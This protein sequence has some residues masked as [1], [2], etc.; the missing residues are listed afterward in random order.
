MNAAF[1]LRA[2]ANMCWDKAADHQPSCSQQ[3]RLRPARLADGLPRTGQVSPGAKATDRHARAQGAI[4]K[5]MGACFGVVTVQVF[6]YL[7]QEK[8]NGRAP[9]IDSTKSYVNG[10]RCRAEIELTAA[11]IL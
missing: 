4:E 11:R 5:A 9:P 6:F 2:E 1:P 8:R 10:P 7:T 3:V